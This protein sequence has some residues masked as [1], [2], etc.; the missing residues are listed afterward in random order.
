MRKKG[1]GFC[2]RRARAVR[3]QTFFFNLISKRLLGIPSR[4]SLPPHSPLDFHQRSQDLLVI[5]PPSHDLQAH[6]SVCVHLWVVQLVAEL[7]FGVLGLVADVLG[8]F[9]GVHGRDREDHAGVVEEVPVRGVAPVLGLAV[10]RGGS[11]GR[12][13]EDHVYFLAVS[14]CVGGGGPGLR[15]GGAVGFSFGGALGAGQYLPAG[16]SR[17]TDRSGDKSRVLTSHS[18]C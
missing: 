11:E 2:R 3:R 12:R 10:G 18:S 13:A 6:R 16:K 7:V 17:S 9:L 8:V 14:V 1:T 5:L 15:V 4:I